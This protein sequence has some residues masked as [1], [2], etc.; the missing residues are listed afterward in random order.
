LPT[1]AEEADSAKAP[2]AGASGAEAASPRK[3]TASAGTTVIGVDL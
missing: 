3:L 1:A 2:E